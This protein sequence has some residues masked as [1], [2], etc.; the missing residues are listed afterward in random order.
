[1]GKASFGWI[2]SNLPKVIYCRRNTI[3]MPY[4]LIHRVSSSHFFKIGFLLFYSVFWSYLSPP[5]LLS[6][7]T[8][9]SNSPSLV[10]WSFFKNIKSSLFYALHLSMVCPPAALVVKKTA[11]PLHSY[12]L[13][14]ETLWPPHHA[15]SEFYLASKC[16]CLSAVST[17][18][19]IIIFTWS[20]VNFSSH[21]SIMIPN[22]LEEGFRYRCSCLE[23]NLQVFNSLHLDQLWVC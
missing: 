6:D 11:C 9:V 7:L 16:A 8:P 13:P 2:K 20:S 19:T 14:L 22:P 17:V 4:F 18:I 15:E 12:Q 5:S 10:S 1:M 21:S 3:W 23:L